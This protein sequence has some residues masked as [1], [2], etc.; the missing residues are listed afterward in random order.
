MRRGTPFWQLNSGNSP[1]ITLTIGGNSGDIHEAERPGKG[2]PVAEIIAERAVNVGDGGGACFDEIKRF[3]E[4][5][6]ET[7]IG[8]KP[9]NIPLEVRVPFP[10]LAPG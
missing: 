9:A 2:N 6:I 3:P 10:I 1:F 7:T 5:G 8:D 4:Q